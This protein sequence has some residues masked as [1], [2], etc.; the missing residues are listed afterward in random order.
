[1]TIDGE[2]ILDIDWYE[3]WR[4]G[5]DRDAP[6]WA[7]REGADIVRSWCWGYME[8]AD[9]S[10]CAVVTL[11]TGQFASVD[12]WTD[13]S[14]WG[15]QDE[16]HWHGPFTTEEEAVAAL[17]QESRRSLGYETPIDHGDI[18]RTG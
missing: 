4:G 16:V 12:W 13:S 17:P 2:R 18:Y 11:A 10:G 8:Y 1:M 3:V 6:E 14:G 15:C 7:V 9:E 5:Q